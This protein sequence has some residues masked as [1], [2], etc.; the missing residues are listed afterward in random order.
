MPAFKVHC[1]TVAGFAAFKNQLS[2]LPHSGK[3]L[4]TLAPELAGYETT[5][6]SLHFPV[7]APLPSRL[8]RQLVAARLGELGLG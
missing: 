2:Y 8:V 7:D 6:G 4:S 1:K 3:V 5:K